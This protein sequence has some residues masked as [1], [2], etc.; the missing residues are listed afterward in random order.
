MT[1]ERQRAETIIRDALDELG[2]YQPDE[3]AQ[4]LAAEG[5]LWCRELRK[6]SCPVHRY[7]VARLRDAL[8]ELALYEPDEIAEKLKKAGMLW[9]GPGER[10]K[11]GPLHHWLEARLVAHGV[12]LGADE[13]ISVGHSRVS[14]GQSRKN[15]RLPSS[16]RAFVCRY[17]FGAYKHLEVPA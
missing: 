11:S 1:T 4:R 13:H 7:L 12:A 16:V 8:H 6:T 2:Q 3:I 15:V 17:D 14:F 5:M 9:C 10:S